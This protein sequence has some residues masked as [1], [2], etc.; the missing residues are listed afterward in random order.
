DGAPRAA[1]LHAQLAAQTLGQV[2]LAAGI[3][4]DDPAA[5]E[6]LD[7]VE[8]L[9]DAAH[10]RHPRGHRRRVDAYPAHRAQIG[11]AP[12]VGPVVADGDVLGHVVP[13]AAEEAVHVAGGD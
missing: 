9:A 13:L 11:L 10:A 12:R 3:V 1:A 5:P 4:L 2:E 7:R 6:Q 8:D